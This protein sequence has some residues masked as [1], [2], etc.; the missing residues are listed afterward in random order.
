MYSSYLPV[1]ARAAFN[2]EARRAT[3]QHAFAHHHAMCLVLN[4]ASVCRIFDRRSMRAHYLQPPRTL[5][6]APSLRTLQFASQCPKCRDYRQRLRLLCISFP[7]SIVAL[8]LACAQDNTGICIFQKKKC[9]AACI[10][11]RC[12][13]ITAWRLLAEWRS[14][15]AISERLP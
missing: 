9:L 15:T 7:L 6:I 1:E 12:F 8:G 13:S 11:A 4:A 10:M 2:D 14:Q 5:G 3:L